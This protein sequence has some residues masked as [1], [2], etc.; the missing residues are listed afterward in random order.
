MRVLVSSNSTVARRKHSIS[1]YSL[2]NFDVGWEILL[3]I[4]SSEHVSLPPAHPKHISMQ[5]QPNIWVQL[6]AET[7]RELQSIDVVYTCVCLCAEWVDWFASYSRQKK[8]LPIQESQSQLYWMFGWL[9]AVDVP[10]PYTRTS[11]CMQKWMETITLIRFHISAITPLTRLWIFISKLFIAN[12]GVAWKR[13]KREEQ[14]RSN[15]GVESPD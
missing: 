2:I 3:I 1:I 9:F 10:S 15:K 5:S 12:S 13:R 14:K 4:F 6:L 11:E 7:E 8:C